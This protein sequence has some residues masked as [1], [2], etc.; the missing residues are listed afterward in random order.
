MSAL[1]LIT[2]QVLYLDGRWVM[3]YEGVGR[4][5]DD[6]SRSLGV[7]VSTDGIEWERID[8]PEGNGSILAQ[9]PAG[10]GRWDHRIGCPWIVPM[11]D[12]SL[13]MHY[14][15]SNERPMGRGADSL[16]AVHQI[17]LAVSDGDL[18]RWRRWSPRP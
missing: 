9:A 7:A 16:V 11:D 6:I 14:I 8:G 18:T 12:G 10:S 13:R 15:G 3:V 2:F 1:P 4:F 5:G 17:G